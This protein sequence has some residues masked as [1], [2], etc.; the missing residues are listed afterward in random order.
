[1]GQLPIRSLRNVPR[2]TGGRME[3]ADADLRSWREYARRRSLPGTSSDTAAQA[4][5][6]AHAVG[7]WKQAPA[8]RR[9]APTPDLGAALRVA[10]NT[11]A[12][13]LPAFFWTDGDKRNSVSHLMRP[14]GW[15]ILVCRVRRCQPWM[16]APSAYIST[17]M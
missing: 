6:K 9:H 7:R 13:A 8:R 16:R 2:E 1:M 10:D 14:P 3:R 4:E 5:T 12:F 11:G 15:R 17:D